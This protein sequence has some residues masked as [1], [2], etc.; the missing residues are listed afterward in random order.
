VIGSHA[1]VVVPQHALEPQH[2]ADVAPSATR[3]AAWPYFSFTLDLRVDS[4]VV[5]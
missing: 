2:A 5:I 1:S 3:S 4:D